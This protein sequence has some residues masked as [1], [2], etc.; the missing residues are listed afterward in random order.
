MAA[1]RETS[2]SPLQLALRV[3]VLVL[4][5][6]A[7]AV[8]ESSHLSSLNTPE[9][10]VHLR[11]GV[12]I[13]E[14]HAI[15]RTGLFPQYPGLRW[16]DSTWLFDQLLGIAYRTF[17]LRAIPLLLMTL[18]VAVALAAFWLARAGSAG[19]WQ[20]V[21]LSATAQY[22]IAGLRPLPYVLS[23]LFLAAELGLLLSSCISGS[24]RRLCWLPLLFVVWANLHIQFDLG[25]DSAHAICHRLAFLAIEVCFQ[26]PML[27]AT[28][29]PA[30]NLC[31]RVLSTV[32][33]T[34]P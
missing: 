1:A 34:N 9:V 17:G 13:L 24:M 31:N 7:G 32:D 10:W 33:R 3:A 6:S 20:S 29:R 15:P 4:V 18:K 14:N 12:W 25:F 11:T 19:F 23:I 8:Y 21:A 26:H 2:A 28:G 30:V 16:D 27:Q 5:F 22:V